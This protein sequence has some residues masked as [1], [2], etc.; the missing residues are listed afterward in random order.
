MTQDN[1]NN[2]D[3]TVWSVGLMTGTVLDGNIDVALL[4]TNGTHV[5]TFGQYTLAPY[6]PETVALLREC[7]DAALAWQFEGA[8][9]AIFAEVEQ[10]L[11]REQSA[12]VRALIDETELSI[13]DISA[14]GF[15]GQT[16]LHRP[17]T[18]HKGV[19]LPGQTRQ[20]GDG[21]LM[22]QIL[23]TTVVND[24]RSADMQAG[25]QGAP[26]CPVYHRALLGGLSNCGETAVLNLG[27]VANLSWWDG[28]S[29]LLAFDTGPA[30]APINDFVRALGRGAMDRDGAFAAQGV[31]DETRLQKLLEHPYLAADYPKSLDRFDFSW[32][33]AEGMPLHDGAALLT[34]FCAAAVG[35]ALERLPQRPTRLIVCGGGRHNSALM[36]ALRQRT[37]TEI[38]A[39][40]AVGWRGDA[41][42]A[43]CFAFLAVRALK[44][45]PLSFPQ[46]T[47]VVQ[48]LTGG[49]INHP[50]A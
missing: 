17:P 23:D 49:Q 24:F 30:N 7:V 19:V 4:K 9:P 36:Q 18:K 33:M 8:E 5:D 44:K 12:A 48:A 42:E 50:V 47:G 37:A 11:T 21:R 43:E 25:G 16:V 15:H 46:T 13:N 32:R 41:M 27:G 10:R 38:V 14:V 2:Q 6:T 1:R 40:E 29:Q 31:V 35:K 45:L 20:L 34:E 3:E 28:G 22:A 26:L 39:A